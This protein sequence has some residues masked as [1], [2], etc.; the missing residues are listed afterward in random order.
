MLLGS[1]VGAG[2]RH[3]KV[4]GDPAGEE[5]PLAAP[6]MEDIEGLEDLDVQAQ[7]PITDLHESDESAQ[8]RQPVAPPPLLS[9]RPPSTVRPQSTIALQTRNAYGGDDSYSLTS[10]Y[11]RG[12]FGSSPDTSRHPRLAGDPDITQSSFYS[13]TSADVTQRSVASSVASSAATRPGGMIQIRPATELE[14]SMEPPKV[15]KASMYRA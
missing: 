9:A 7:E 13:V 2:L 4:I 14:Y 5:P 6:Y 15:S 3:V 1:L 10:I 8:R 12:Y 11:G